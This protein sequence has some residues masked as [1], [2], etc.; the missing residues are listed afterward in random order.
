VH[1]HAV[2]LVCPYV[3][4]C[5]VLYV[6]SRLSA[7]IVKFIFVDVHASWRFPCGVLCVTSVGFAC[8]LSVMCAW[9][10]MSVFDCFVFV[11]FPLYACVCLLACVRLLAYVCLD[12]FCM[13]LYACLLMSLCAACLFD[14]LCERL[15]LC[16]VLG[17]TMMCFCG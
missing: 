15:F 17:G 16:C 7:R 1:G 3:W 11:C 5:V 14:R 12:L 2:L 10:G 4:W 8:C 13:C 9:V 6:C